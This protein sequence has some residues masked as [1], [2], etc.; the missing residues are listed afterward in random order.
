[1]PQKP[2]ALWIY[3]QFEPETQYKF[4]LEFNGELYLRFSIIALNY[5]LRLFAQPIFADVLDLCSR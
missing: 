3:S 4:F 2:G 5:Y 1:M